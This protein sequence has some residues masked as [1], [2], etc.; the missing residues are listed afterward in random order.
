MGSLRCRAPAADAGD[1]CTCK[2]RECT[3]WLSV[4]PACCQ[5]ICPSCCCCY[6]CPASRQ[7][8]F[9]LLRSHHAAVCAAILLHPT[10]AP[11]LLLSACPGKRYL[12]LYLVGLTMLCLSLLLT[13][14]TPEEPWLLLVERVWLVPSSEV[15]GPNRDLQQLLEQFPDSWAADQVRKGRLPSSHFQLQ[16]GGPGIMKHSPLTAHM[17]QVSV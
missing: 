1:T 17:L 16:V 8:Q 7:P 3:H 14:C 12:A 11:W 2:Q 13:C 4:L 6:Q 9:Q 15:L 10:T 5:R